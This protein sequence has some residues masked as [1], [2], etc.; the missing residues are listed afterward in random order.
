MDR[1][2]QQQVVIFVLMV[3]MV[4]ESSFISACPSGGRE[5][6]TCILDRFKKDCPPCA[7]ILRCMAQCLWSGT[8]Q[9][10]CIKYCD[11]NNR[12]PNIYDCKKCMSKC[13][14]SCQAR[15]YLG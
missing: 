3:A 11:C 7:P 5:C 12:Y 4:L 6:K 15:P 13:K 10:K 14:C 2:K 8:S 1:S 9:G